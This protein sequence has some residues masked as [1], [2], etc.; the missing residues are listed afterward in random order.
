MT[1]PQ[2]HSE[3]FACPVGSFLQ[4]VNE[5]QPDALEHV[6]NAAHELLEVARSAIDTAEAAIVHQRTVHRERSAPSRVRRIDIV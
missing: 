2:F 6:L 3:C 5:A 4:G 1:E